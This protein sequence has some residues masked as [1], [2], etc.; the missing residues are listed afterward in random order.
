MKIIST[1]NPAIM[2]N[3]K[4]LIIKAHASFIDL[5]VGVS[6][7]HGA[8]LCFVLLLAFGQHSK[9]RINVRSAPANSALT[10]VSHQSHNAHTANCHLYAVV[11][12][13]ME[14]KGGQR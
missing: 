2:K 12:K 13:G 7:N 8:S 5:K 14:L 4:R 6:L 10:L 1:I 9:Q 11:D 3:K